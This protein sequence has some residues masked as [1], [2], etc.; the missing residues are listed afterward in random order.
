VSLM[1]EPAVDQSDNLTLIAERPLPWAHVKPVAE[2]KRALL[3]VI[4]ASPGLR[5]AEIAALVAEPAGSTATRLNRLGDRGVIERT[6]DHQWFITGTAPDANAPEL[7]EFEIAERARPPFDPTK[8]VQNI[9]RYVRYE[10][11][12]FACARFG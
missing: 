11:S 7:S 5:Q 1:D 8:W 6:P 10:T 3:A 12:M 9:D 2:K 4:A